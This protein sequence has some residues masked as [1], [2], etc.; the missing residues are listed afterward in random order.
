MNYRHYCHFS[1]L[2][3]IQVPKRAE[4]FSSQGR[5]DGGIFKMAYLL[6]N[7]IRTNDLNYIISEV[8]Y[9]VLSKE[10]NRVLYGELVG[11]TECVWL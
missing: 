9:V 6:E 10:E 2:K 4:D 8:V 7:Y 3:F 1:C 11:T 5:G